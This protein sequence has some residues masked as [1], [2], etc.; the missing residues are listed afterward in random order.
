MCG[1]LGFRGT[2]VENHFFTRCYHSLYTIITS[3]ADVNTMP[4]VY[5]SL[6]RVSGITEFT[7]KVTV[8]GFE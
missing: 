7:Q 6:G 5:L 1:T 4:G 3:A 2:P 8:G